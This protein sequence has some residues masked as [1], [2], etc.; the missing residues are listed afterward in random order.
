MQARE[1]IVFRP[2]MRPVP[3]R[4]TLFSSSS[5]APLL[6]RLRASV[7]CPA[8]TAAPCHAFGCRCY[9]F[10]FWFGTGPGRGTEL[11]GTQ[12]FRTGSGSVVREGT[13][14][15]NQLVGTGASTWTKAAF[16][17]G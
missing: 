5:F 12:G 13:R 10:R 4:E 6:L 16:G 14:S 1:Q 11:M 2:G 9:C 8:K 17:V 7:L 3:S 15:T